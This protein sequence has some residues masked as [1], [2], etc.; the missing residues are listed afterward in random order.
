MQKSTFDYVSAKL[1]LEA[2]KS[3]VMSDLRTSMLKGLPW[4]SPFSTLSVE[5]KPKPRLG[6]KMGIH[7]E[8]PEDL[9]GS[10]L[11][12]SPLF[13]VHLETV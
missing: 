2:Q 11:K 12:Y 1:F 10:F 8:M 7:G 5:G 3:G 4:V 9:K 13:E 6:F